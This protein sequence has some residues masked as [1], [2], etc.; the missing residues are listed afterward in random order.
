MLLK[1]KTILCSRD[2]Y[3][4]A[5]MLICLNSIFELVF[6]YRFQ[7]EL[8]M[9]VIYFLIL[10][11]ISVIAI[12]NRVKSN[13]KTYL[14][15]FY[16]FWPV[17]M[18]FIYF[19]S[20]CKIALLPLLLSSYIMLF[21][22]RYKRKSIKIG[23]AVIMSIFYVLIALFIYFFPFAL[24]AMR[25]PEVVE[26]SYSFDHKYIMVLEETDLGATGG[27]V[28]V[29]F[30]RNID[31]GLLGHYMPMKTKYYGHWGERPDFSFV[32]NHLI[33]INGELI[34]MKGRNYLSNNELYIKTKPLT[35][36]S[37]EGGE[38]ARYK[39]ENG[40]ILQYKVTLYGETG[41][42]EE[43]YY[44]IED[45]AIYYTRS[46]IRY[47]SPITVNKGTDRLPRTFHEGTII[48]GQLYYSD[49]STGDSE[50]PDGVESMYKNLEEL[51]RAFDNA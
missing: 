17:I 9:E 2:Y 32:N 26:T 31:F 27:N 33:S 3:E 21:A 8:K 38:I 5:I 23:M 22:G 51:N 29:Y 48:N 19:Y 50:K 39:K 16:C 1:I 43:N 47:G 6:Q 12:K 7:T 14:P 10:G 42:I 30:G 36:E 49:K 45:S 34:E 4:I 40:D 11:A 25:R 35:G 41:R 13:Q 46:E 24:S 44:F 18:S 20:I 37:A 15:V 28:D